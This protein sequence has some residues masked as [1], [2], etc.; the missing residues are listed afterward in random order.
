MYAYTSKG[1]FLLER[2]EWKK[3]SKYGAEILL[4]N[5]V[6]AA[7]E[8]Y[9]IDGD[10]RIHKLNSKKVFIGHGRSSDRKILRNFIEKRLNLEYEE[11]NRVSSA[12]LNTQERLMEML[13]NCGFAF[14]VLTGED[15]HK[16]NAT[17]ARE[18]VIHE[19]GLF[20]SR[21]GWRRAI[22]LLESGCQEFSN[23]VG[24]TQL[25]FPKVILLAPSKKF[26]VS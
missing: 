23:I 19:T 13:E 21:L 9:E 15:V 18:N 3:L 5:R 26:D 12:G 11:F 22:I 10:I 14:L 1:P 16:D 20:Q 25:R 4:K 8:R 24:L 7:D 2:G 17:H 6:S